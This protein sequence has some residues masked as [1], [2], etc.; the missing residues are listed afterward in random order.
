MTGCYPPRIGFGTF[1]GRLVLFPGQG[2]GLSDNET[3]I[4]DVLKARGYVTMHVGKWH[5]GDLSLPKT[6][7]AFM[8]KDLR[9]LPF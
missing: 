3:T 8:D 2:V 6:P 7:S 1:E 9:T 5:C 4:A